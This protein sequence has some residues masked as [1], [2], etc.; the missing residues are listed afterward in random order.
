MVDMQMFLDDINEFI[1][2]D[3]IAI[4]I[5]VDADTVTTGVKLNISDKDKIEGGEIDTRHIR[6]NTMRLVLETIGSMALI[7]QSKRSLK[8]LHEFTT[9]EAYK[10]QKGKDDGII[11]WTH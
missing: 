5:S 6:N 9:E 1:P 2:N 8:K 11:S 7:F 3:F 10:L 4:G